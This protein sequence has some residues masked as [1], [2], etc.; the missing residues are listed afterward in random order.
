MDRKQANDNLMDTHDR[1][2]ADVLTR[3]RNILNLT[4]LQATRDTDDLE[5]HNAATDNPSSIAVTGISLKME[6]DALYSSIKELLTLSRRMKELWV[7]GPLG[8]RESQG[9]EERVRDD[10]KRVGE[11][12]G[13]IE[14]GR[15]KETAEAMG[16]S[17]ELKKDEEVKGV[18][19]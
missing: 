4:T 7:F 15:A 13:D 16:G 3:Y 1:L 11:L 8:G 9:M 17:W 6:F 14:G 12:L 5:I 10:V 18:E 19:A 2:I